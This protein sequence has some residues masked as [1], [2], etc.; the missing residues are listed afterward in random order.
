[1]GLWLVSGEREGGR[2]G[3]I[4]VIYRL[5]VMELARDTF[6]SNPWLAI[7]LVRGVCL[8]LNAQKMAL[9]AS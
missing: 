9:F 2:E 1:M 6:G 5:K 8:G 7:H 3:V 4:A